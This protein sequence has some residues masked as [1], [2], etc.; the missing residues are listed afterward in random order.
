[1]VNGVRYA[2]KA[3]CKYDIMPV[4]IKTGQVH[5]NTFHGLVTND[6][7]LS[8]H[9]EEV[10]FNKNSEPEFRLTTRK[11]NLCFRLLVRGKTPLPDYVYLPID[12]LG[13][14]AWWKIR[15]SLLLRLKHR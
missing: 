3:K 13:S 15:I 1:M 9:F 7:H 12:I 8:L 11:S 14:T 4:I 10:G 2:Y 6:L 5:F